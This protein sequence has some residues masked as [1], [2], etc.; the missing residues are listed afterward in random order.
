MMRATAIAGLALAIPLC[1][2]AGAAEPAWWTQQKRQCGLAPNLAYNVWVAQGSPCAGAYRPPPDPRVALR[3]RVQALAAADPELVDASALAQT[4]LWNDESFAGLVARLHH[5]LWRAYANSEVVTAD[6]SRVTQYYAPHLA[7]LEAFASS[8][9]ARRADAVPPRYVDALDHARAVEAD[10]QRALARARQQ[11]A[12]ESLG[13]TFSAA[14]WEDARNRTLAL[15]RARFLKAEGL[16]AATDENGRGDPGDRLHAPAG[17]FHE[18]W[19]GPEPTPQQA[20][21][22]VIAP[23]WNPDGFRQA[24]PAP[25]PPLPET[26]DDRVSAVERLAGEARAAASR[27][28]AAA[29]DGRR[30]EERYRSYLRIAEKAQDGIARMQTE[31]DLSQRRTTWLEAARRNAEMKVRNAVW[32]RVYATGKALV[33]STLA[34]RIVP[35]TLAGLANDS[36]FE[37]ARKVKALVDQVR[38]IEGD[39]ELYSSQAARVLAEGSPAEARHLLDAVWAASRADGRETME[40]ALDAA[41]APAALGQA[42]RRLLGDPQ[43]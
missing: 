19:L 32:T 31:T 37:K 33:W 27:A 35:D 1:A 38:G 41:D 12:D 39:F 30:L 24:V 18:P 34:D 13:A 9:D 22:G 2:P 17:P 3:S 5:D 23:D 4:D 25:E 10:A 6:W 43:P 21:E 16:P 29:A 11:A 36:P 15:M 20:A 7:R 26:I 40:K 42:W 14:L 8:L 28:A